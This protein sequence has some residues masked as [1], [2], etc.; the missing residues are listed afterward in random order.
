MDQSPTPTERVAHQV[1]ETLAG[2]RSARRRITGAVVR[3]TAMGAVRGTRWVGRGAG[4]LAREAVEGTIQAVGEISGETSAF[5]RDA[6][7]GVVQGAS[8]VVTV[9]TPAVREVVVGAIRGTEKASAGASEVSRDAVEGAIVGAVSVGI[10]ASE[11]AVAAVEGV[12]DAVVETGGDLRD[13]AQATVGGVLSGVAAA[14]GDLAAATHDAAYALVAHDAV[15]ERHADEVAAVADSTVDAAFQE[16]RRADVET[17]EVVAAAAAGV[18]EAAYRVSRSHGESVRQSVMRRV[19]GSGLAI[20]PGL[21]RGLSEVAERL[22]AELPK[23]RAAWRG[24]A[25]VRAAKLLIGAGGIDL[26]GSLAYF[27]VLSLLPSVALVI[28]IVALVGDPEAIRERLTSVLVYYFPTS[29]VL[30]QEAVENLFRGSLAI[31]VVATASIVIGANG[32]FLAANRAIN[33]VFG[34]GVRRA[35]Q[36]TVAQV[37]I[38]TVVVVLFLLSVGLTASLQTALRFGEGIAETTGFLSSAVVITLGVVSTV[39]PA[40]F[41]MVVFA[42]VYFRMP[43]VHVE[44]RDATFG[45]MAAIV[46]FEAGKHLFFWFTGFA[47]QRSAVYGPITSVVVLLMWAYAAG[48]IFLYGAALAR[49]AGELRPSGIRKR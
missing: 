26:A 40:F 45:A 9:T 42:V 7:V 28:M 32:L 16:A 5:V 14:G 8:Q 23:G 1:R 39:L 36:I 18:V 12:V 47:S 19:V 49:A 11:A 48:M 6:V 2:N 41:T 10:D 22:S 33:R 46:L 30:I 3:S 35:V 38:T 31:G 44:W 25:V 13:A 21:E 34:V 17:G 20:A 29:Q 15:A 4:S 37:T 24:A 43:N 27:M